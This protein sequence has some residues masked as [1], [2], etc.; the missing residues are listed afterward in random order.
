SCHRVVERVLREVRRRERGG[1]RR[2]ERDD[3]EGGAPAVRAGQAPEE[4]E[5]AARLP[6]GPVVDGRTALGQQVAAGLVDP[7]PAPSP[8]TPAPPLE[9]TP[10]T[11]RPPSPR[12]PR[13]R[14]RTAAG[15][16][17]ARRSRGR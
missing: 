17:R 16:D 11:R 14:P 5:P 12:E 6:P 10:V 3:R 13:R 1:R 15:G 9:P 4:A 8:A 2:E 7:H